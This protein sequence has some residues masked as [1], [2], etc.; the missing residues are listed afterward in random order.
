MSLL[1]RLSVFQ[2]VVADHFPE[3]SRD[4]QPI[5]MAYLSLNFFMVGLTFL[6]LSLITININSSKCKITNRRQRR[7]LFEIPS[8]LLCANKYT[9][10]KEHY[11]QNHNLEPNS[12]MQPAKESNGNVETTDNKWFSRS[13]NDKGVLT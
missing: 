7:I 10:N 3:N 11:E 9:T 5:V 12:T 4:T 2:L 13:E 8:R 6:T 1:L